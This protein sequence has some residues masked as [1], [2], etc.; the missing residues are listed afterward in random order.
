MSPYTVGNQHYGYDDQ[1]QT[2]FAGTIGLTCGG[3]IEPSPAI[4]VSHGG[5]WNVCVAIDNNLEGSA[6]LDYFNS[7]TSILAGQ[8]NCCPGATSIYT[9][10]RTILGQTWDGVG[11]CS[12][13]F[14]KYTYPG[15][16]AGFVDRREAE[17][18]FSGPYNQTLLNPA[19]GGIHIGGIGNNCG[20]QG[21]T[22][23]LPGYETPPGSATQPLIVTVFP[24]QQ[25][26]GTNSDLEELSFVIDELY[27][28]CIAGQVSC[29]QWQNAYRNAM[30]Q[31]PFPAP[32]QALH[33]IQVSRATQAWQLANMTVNGLTPLQMLEITTQ[34]VFTPTGQIGPMGMGGDVGSDGGL[35]QSW[36]K[37]SDTPEPNFQAMV[38]FDPNMPTWFMPICEVQPLPSQCL[39]S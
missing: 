15:S 2:S 10:V 30:N 37:G 1:I 32:R 7:L 12:M 26:P 17:Y 24:S 14:Q 18:G 35:G 39:I 36:G 33:F 11:G 25:A 38:A 21:Q 6:S 20:T 3:N 29:S 23:Y 5:Y 9:Y 16:F 22:W 28:Q 31:Y 27:M 4:G 13:P 8:P 34:Q 19:N